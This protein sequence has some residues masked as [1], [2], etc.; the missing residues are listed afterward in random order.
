MLILSYRGR[1]TQFFI[2]FVIIKTENQNYKAI[3]AAK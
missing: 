1:F 2:T 3:Q